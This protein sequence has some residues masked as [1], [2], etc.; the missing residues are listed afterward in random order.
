MLDI[1]SVIIFGGNGKIG[2]RITNFLL[3][4]SFKVVVISRSKNS[5]IELNVNK[6][7][8]H[9]NADMTIQSSL[10]KALSSAYDFL[11][12]LSSVVFSSS[13]RPN[14]QNHSSFENITPWIDSVTKNALSIYTPL[15]RLI[16][17]AL[18]NKF[19]TSFI[20]ISSIY[21]LVA[22]DFTIYDGT[23]LGT[24][25]DY[26]Y[27]K[28]A[29]ISLFKYFA[30][31]YGVDGLRF[32]SIAPGGFKDSQSETFVNRYSSKVP[33]GRMAAYEDICELIY[34]LSQKSSSYLNGSCIPLDGGWTCR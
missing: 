27:N 9:L 20:N 26:V 30:S 31:K 4:K 29:S 32:N 19:C 3:K 18:K 5:A 22:P 25:S 1:N 13:Y 10:D 12:D 6:N 34:L 2:S 7:L 11:G 14:L 28:S 21:G 16:P 24:E 33:T 23:D 15:S 17:F 8:I